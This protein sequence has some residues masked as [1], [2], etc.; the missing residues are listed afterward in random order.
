LYAVHFGGTIH[1]MI[2]AGAATPDNVPDTLS[3][4]G[5]FS[6][7]DPTQ[8]AGGLIP[9]DINAPFWSDGAE[10]SRYFAL[11]EGT[12]ITI[13]ADN[14]WTFP[15]GA[16]IVKNFTLG[17][18]LIETRLMMRHPD[19]VW[20]GYTYEWNAAETVANRVR[21][22][23]VRTVN[24]Q[25]WIYP[26]ES[27]CMECHTAA[28][29][30]ALGPETAQLNKDF[31]YPSTSRTANQMATLEHIGV[32]SAPLSGTLPSLI[33][34]ADTAAPLESRARSYLHTN[35]SQCHR[36][37]GPTPSSM[38]LHYDTSFA[39]TN[40]CN[41]VPEDGTLGLAN[42]RIVVPGDASRSVLAAR[43]NRRDVYGMPPLASNLVDTEGVTLITDWINALGGCP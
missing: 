14:D 31:T 5:C 22:G 41:V 18:L 34:P 17:G 26:S 43:M 12:T 9:Y 29:G 6:A 10:K 11:P 35:C 39:A 4:P 38:D 13:G 2:S 7:V 25:D 23:K 21:D 28:A 19:G 27:Q 30:F 40:T 32:F 37:G 16:V 33:D 24:G 20:A 36:P 42:A 8:P 1:K 15:P 3:A